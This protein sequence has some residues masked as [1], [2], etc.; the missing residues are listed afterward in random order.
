[1]RECDFCA[2]AIQDLSELTMEEPENKCLLTVNGIEK[3]KARN[4]PFTKPGRTSCCY[5][6]SL[7]CT[8]QPGYLP[9]LTLPSTNEDSSVIGNKDLLAW[10]QDGQ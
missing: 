7:S 3:Q 4:P 9:L 8:V 10:K 5:Y 2:C 1:M 6:A